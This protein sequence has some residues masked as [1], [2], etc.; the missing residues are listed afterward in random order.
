MKL[1]ASVFCAGDYIAHRLYLA[2]R[3][4]GL[5]IGRD[6]AVIGFDD[7]PFAR[8]LS[9]PLSTIRVDTRRLGYLA[10]QLLHRSATEGFTSPVHLKVPAEFIERESL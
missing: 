4:A 3:E 7:L 5:Q 2:A 9:P 1:P 8:R 6:L 10:A